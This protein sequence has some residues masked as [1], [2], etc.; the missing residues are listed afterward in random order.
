[1]SASHEGEMTRQICSVL[2]ILTV[3]TISAA[4]GEVAPSA[5]LQST[6]PAKSSNPSDE[7]ALRQFRQAIDSYMTLERKLRAEV[8]P[9]EVTKDVAKIRAASDTLAV[10]VQRARPQARQGDF[11]DPAARRIFAERLRRALEGN[12]ADDLLVTIVDDPTIKS[13]PQVHMRYP[14][15]SSMSTM[16][17]RFLEVLPQLPDELEYRLVGTDLILRDRDAALILDYFPQAVPAARVK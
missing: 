5:L 17:P 10:A 14:L 1:M 15:D 7:L 4:A 16:P 3:A 13:K 9:F 6:V 12:D 2:L 11:F 8:P